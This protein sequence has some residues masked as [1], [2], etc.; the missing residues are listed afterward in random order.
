MKMKNFLGAI[1]LAA[2]A[3]LSAPAASA[4]QVQV[5]YLSPNAL[6]TEW[7]GIAASPNRRVFEVANQSSEAAAKNAAKYECEQ[8]L[9]AP[10]RR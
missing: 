8:R 10:V 4:R 5:E 6:V 1:G 9:A 7:I 2:V 3:A